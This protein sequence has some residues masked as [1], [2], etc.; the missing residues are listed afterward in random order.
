MSHNISPLC[1]WLVIPLLLLAGCR[2]ASPPTTSGT[3]QGAVG[4]WRGGDDNHWIELTKKGAV[5]IVTDD[6][7]L[8]GNYTVQGAAVTP[9]F[10]ATGTTKPS[11]SAGIWR[12]QWTQD[13]LQVTNPEN[14]VDEYQ[15][16]QPDPKLKD[17]PLLGRWEWTRKGTSH[18]N[19]LEFTPSGT[20][21][22]IRWLHPKDAK[23]EGE[24]TPKPA[25][26]KPKRGGP[27]ELEELREAGSFQ[28]EG[29]HLHLTTIRHHKS[30]RKM[31]F[32]IVSGLDVDKLVITHTRPN[33]KTATANYRRTL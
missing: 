19:S 5:A 6:H 13:K 12:M 20:F 16:S 33:G 2:E 30:S 8:I 24:A 15:R 1:R 28:V 29:K 7:A 10:V 18:P 4:H 17:S 3:S 26:K 27:G 32:E 21:I 11:R 22:S 14:H 9:K 31:Q 23:E 25:A